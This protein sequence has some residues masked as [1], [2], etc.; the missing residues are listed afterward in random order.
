MAVTTSEPFRF[1]TA[2]RDTRVLQIVGQIIFA[3]ILIAALYG[4][5][6]SILGALS[7]QNLTP[8]LA[9]LQNRA[10]FPIGEAPPWYTADESYWTAYTIGLTNTLRIVILGLILSTVVGILV[11]IFLL[12]NNWLV[13]TISKVYVE[14]LRN[15]PL[16]VQLFIWY[17][18]VMLSLPAFQQSIALPQEG[19]TFI[20]IR[21]GLYLLAGVYLYSQLGRI[22]PQQH[23]R[24]ALI[25]PAFFA[26]VA[27]IELGFWVFARTDV[28]DPR[29]LLFVVISG[30]ILLALAFVA[31]DARQAAIGGLIGLAIGAV[32]F[33][34][35]IIPDTALRLEMQPWIFLNIR[36]FAFPELLPTGRLVEWL[37]FVAVGVAL[38]FILWIYLGRVTET[39]GQRFPRVTYALLSIVIFAVVGW[40]LVSAEP[41]PSTIPVTNANGQTVLMTLDEAREAELLPLEAE[42]VYA[43]TPLLFKLPTKN[44]FRFTGGTQITPEYLA[45]LLGLTIY[46]SAF[47]AEIVRAGILAVPRGQVEAARALGL[48][49][50]DLLR[51]VILPQALRVII[52]PLGNQYLNLTKNSSLAIAIAYSDLFQITTIIM[53]QSGQSVTGMIMVMLTYLILSLIIATIMSRLNRRFQLVTR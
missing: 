19:Y 32:L 5:L 53:N 48:N 41:S 33:F 7:A 42:Q 13:R 11:G 9:F 27:V 10:G 37:A 16:L 40:L 29:M 1:S 30:A 28:N 39:S 25:V 4:L 38:A 12:S 21:I 49:Y 6:T 14:L 2:L 22:P 36:G 45:L 51:L 52:P 43:Q 50:T 20:P 47:I 46:T 44:N 17:F 8:N 34:T 24:R 35:R 31:K 23:Q 3:V 18:V 15:T 26:A